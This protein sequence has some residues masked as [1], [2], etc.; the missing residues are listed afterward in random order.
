MKKLLKSVE[1]FVQQTL[2]AGHQQTLKARQLSSITPYNNLAEYIEFINFLNRREVEKS[3]ADIARNVVFIDE[4]VQLLQRQHWSVSY[5]TLQRYLQCGT[6]IKLI[7]TAAVE[8]KKRVSVDP[9]TFM[10]GVKDK[11]GRI[12][13]KYNRIL[14]EIVELMK[15][16]ELK[17]A[18]KLSHMA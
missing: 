18:M 11:K 8:N 4:N 12:F 9:Y 13:Q 5:A 17:S 15:V 6:W 3:I 14:K 10:K 7:R 1:D 2:E 16:G